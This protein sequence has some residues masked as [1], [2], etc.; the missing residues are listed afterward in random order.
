METQRMKLININS[1]KTV[2]IRVNTEGNKGYYV[3]SVSSNLVE[4][5]MFL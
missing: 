3:E 2:Y 5:L 4:N 1:K